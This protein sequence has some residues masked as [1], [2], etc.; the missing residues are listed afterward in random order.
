MNEYEMIWQKAEEAGKKA[1]NALNKDIMSYPCGFAWVRVKPANSTFAKWLVSNN[2]A[3][4]DSYQ[5][6]VL[7][8]VYDYNQSADH[9]EA[10][11]C[12]MANVF[13]EFG[14]KCSAGSRLD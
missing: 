6:G 10:H 3:M 5:G 2:Y 12:A 8:W 9:K 4:K 14:I 13:E 7:I 11:A 1:A